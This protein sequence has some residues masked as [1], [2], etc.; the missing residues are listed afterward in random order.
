MIN[1]FRKFLIPCLVIL[2]SMAVISCSKE[3]GK[4]GNS[5]IYGKV[6]VKNYNSTFTFLQEEYYGQ[7]EEVYLIYGDDRSYNGNL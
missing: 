7:D 2:L 4:G 3:P 6:Y 5:T 1:S